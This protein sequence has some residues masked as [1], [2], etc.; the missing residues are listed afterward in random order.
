[1]FRLPTSKTHSDMAHKSTKSI[2][3]HM[4]VPAVWN[5]VQ[6]PVRPCSIEPTKLNLL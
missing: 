3:F 1:M 5:V 4:H 2:Q 6:T